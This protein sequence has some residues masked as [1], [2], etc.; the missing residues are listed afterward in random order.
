M[1]K[2]PTDPK[3]RCFFCRR[4]AAEKVTLITGYDASICD[5]CVVTCSQ[6][7][8]G[9][10]PSAGPT[11]LP[12]LE[13]LPKP[14]EIK[15]YLDAYIIGQEKAKKS[16]SVAVYNHYKRVFHPKAA[17]D[18]ELEKSN[19]LL[20][21]PT[22]TGKTLMADTLAKMLSVPFAIADATVLTE[23]GYVGEDVENILV[24]LLQ[25]ADYDL[26]RAER[27]IVYIDEIDKIARKG[28]SPSITRDVSGEG[29]QQGLL[30]ILEGT[31]SNIPP[32]GGRK[33]PEQNF[34][35]LNTKNILFIC[36][37]AFDGLDKLVARR[38][39]R[40]TV[41]FGAKHTA[42]SKEK[43]GAI[44]S[45]V[46]PED[47]LAYGLIPELIG[48]LPVVSALEELDAAALL[49]I[50]TEP[51]NAITKQYQKLF[52]MEGIELVFEPEALNAVVE[53]AQKRKTGARA[54]RSILEEA[55][56]EVMFELPSLQGV[57]RCT[58]SK[59]SIVEKQKPHLFYGAKRKTA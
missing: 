7:L 38:V 31:I 48:R 16:V 29:V 47:L 34:V 30:K 46:E 58:V 13:T 8:A 43:Q 5:A 22:G 57:I 12:A 59:A 50:L 15:K 20:I 36:G 54:L 21:G 3:E 18:V 1:P 10:K 23:A 35:P 52:E 6:F 37:G 2:K 42:L 44:F 55:M 28:D 39:G 11:P 56:L 17:A 14:A 53:S 33:H 4:P 19:I 41:G 27:G 51:K 25:A 49:K 24:R 45:L 32:K 40:K 9:K 26:T